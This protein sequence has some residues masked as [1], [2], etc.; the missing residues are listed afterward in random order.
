MPYLIT[1]QGRQMIAKEQLPADFPSA[2]LVEPQQVIFKAADGW[3][4]HG[5]LFVPRQHPAKGPAVVFIH[6][7]SIRQMILGFH[8]M[9]YYHNAYAENQYLASLGYVVLSIN[10]RTGV[11]YGRAFREPA[12]GGWRGA[13]EYQDLYAAGKYLQTLAYV[14]AQ[15]IGLWGGSY[16]GFMTAMGLARN[17][18]LFKAGV[19]LHGVHD[20]SVFLAHWGELT[21][22]RAAGTP[23]DY[24]Q[25]VKLAFESSPNSS[26]DKWRS[27]VLLI[28][29]DDDRNVPFSQTVDLA[30]RLRDR[31]IP[32][33]EIAFPDEIHDFLR[34][35]SWMHAYAA[36]ADFFDRTL[37]K[38]QQ[39]GVGVVDQ[40]FEE[41]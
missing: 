41:H 5:Q 20:W 17:S 9:N 37:V 26:V 34:W 14:D 4:I 13:A 21:G 31:K 23:P 6:G 15:K 40:K 30:E 11:M 19:D 7:G 25:A 8:Y 33:E 22:A 16:G 36:A 10:Y 18:D 38:G 27:P 24:E 1:A 39:I 12:N 28:Q 32:F 29:G 35:S 3:D 2:Q